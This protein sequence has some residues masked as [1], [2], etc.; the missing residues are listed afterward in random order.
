[1][2]DAMSRA[3]EEISEKFHLQ[4]SQEM[5]LTMFKTRYIN[6]RLKRMSCKEFFE[7]DLGRN[8]MIK[9]LLPLT[10]V[11]IFIGG[12]ASVSYLPSDSSVIYPP[13]KKVNIYW[14]KPDFQ[15]I[16]IGLLSIE[17]KSSEEAL[18][19]KIKK[20]AMEIGAD[21]II[22]KPATQATRAS[23]DRRRLEAIAIKFKEAKK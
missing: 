2:K 23:K 3:Y 5:V 17:S 12:C 6:L 10:V 7:K 1:M 22:V 19:E 4:S 20:K 18:F 8:A 14:S 21:G 11:M 15:Y 13:T 9:R 16:E